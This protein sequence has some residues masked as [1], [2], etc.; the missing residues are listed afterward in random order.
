M[1]VEDVANVKYPVVCKTHPSTGQCGMDV[2]AIKVPGHHDMLR[3]KHVNR[4]QRYAF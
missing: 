3:F 2:V 4:S 1:T